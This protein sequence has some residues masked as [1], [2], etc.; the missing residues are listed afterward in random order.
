M[1]GVVRGEGVRAHQHGV[2]QRLV[3][4]LAVVVGVAVALVGHGVV[5]LHF[6]QGGSIRSMYSAAQRRGAAARGLHTG[7]RQAGAEGV[8]AA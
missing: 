6:C 2:V 8:P 4:R 3:Q 5:H 1:R 7:G